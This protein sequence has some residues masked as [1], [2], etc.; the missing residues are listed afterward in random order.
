MVTILFC[1][2]CRG[3]VAAPNLRYLKHLFVCHKWALKS[4]ISIVYILSI[5]G[6]IFFFPTPVG[7]A[8]SAPV[9]TPEIRSRLQLA[10]PA[11][12]VN[13]IESFL[14]RQSCSIDPKRRARIAQAIVS[15]AVEFDLDPRL[16][17]AIAVV[18]SRCDSF[19]ISQ[20]D[21]VG[22]M[23]IHLPTWS[24]TI[25]H[26]GINVF[27]I[28][29]NIYLGARILASYVNQSGLWGGVHRY[30]GAFPDSPESMK[31][32]DEYVAKVQSIYAKQ[33]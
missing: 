3:L 28:E 15:S 10:P 29:D 18:E 14:G 4:I 6:L 13:S 23:Q 16:L 7:Q 20:F 11:L 32:A 31:T 8:S 27:K 19:A 2:A 9:G 1:P 30:H 12:T 22:I 21:S 26:E 5:A 17:A 24:E 25:D 33:L